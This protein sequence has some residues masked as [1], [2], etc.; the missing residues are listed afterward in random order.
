MVPVGSSSFLKEQSL[1]KSIHSLKYPLS[2]F[3]LTVSTLIL[4]DNNGSVN[5]TDSDNTNNTNRQFLKA[6]TMFQAAF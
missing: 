3:F 4:S 5:T 1:L 6:L 2:T